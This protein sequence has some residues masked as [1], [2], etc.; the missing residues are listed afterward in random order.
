VK[1]LFE[2]LTD[3]L[4]FEIARQ[5][6]ESIGNLDDLPE[7]QAMAAMM[8][9]IMVLPRGVETV[10][11]IREEVKQE[12]AVEEKP[13]KRG[14]RKAKSDAEVDKIAGDLLSEVNI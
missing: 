6:K 7:Q 11:E 13:K 12:K 10:H 2:C 3:D 8:T 9:L 1:P 5:Y 4:R 14:G